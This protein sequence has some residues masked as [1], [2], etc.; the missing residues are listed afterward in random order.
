MRTR[1]GVALLAVVIC[2]CPLLKPKANKDDAGAAAVTLP[3]ATGGTASATASVA[4]PAF[5]PVALVRGDL[6]RSDLPQWRRQWTLWRAA[7]RYSRAMQ[8]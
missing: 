5:L 1:A 8:G 6:A 3:S 2:G 4:A 7:R